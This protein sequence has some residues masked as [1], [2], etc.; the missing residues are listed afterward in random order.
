MKTQ[1]QRCPNKENNG[2]KTRKVKDRKQTHVNESKTNH[3]ILNPGP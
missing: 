1:I 3:D 2:N